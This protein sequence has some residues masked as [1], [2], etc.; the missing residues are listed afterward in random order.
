M[1][2]ALAAR[3]FA[4]PPVDAI[5]DLELESLLDLTVDVATRSPRGQRE[6]AGIVTVWDASDLRRLGCRDLADALSLIPEIQLGV[7][8]WGTTGLI[9]RGSWAFEGRVLVLVDG[10]ELN[11]TD[12]GTVVLGHRLP[13]SL[14]ERIEVLRGPGSAMYGGYASLS[15]V[16]VTTF[17]GRGDTGPRV[18]ATG[19]V[20]ASGVP[21]R[22]DVAVS[23][24]KTLEHGH[25]AASAVVG[26]GRR[27][28][29]TYTD[30]AGG[31][32]DLTHASQADPA[33][34]SADAEVGVWTMA[35]A[36][37][38]FHTTQQ[39]ANVRAW[40]RPHDADFDGIFGRLEANVRP[41]DG[42]TVRPYLRVKWQQP[43]HSTDWSSMSAYS[44]TE[45]RV[46]RT[47]LGVEAATEDDGGWTLQGGAEGGIDHATVPEVQT[48]WWFDGG[49]S[50]VYGFGSGWAQATRTLPA[51]TL[52]AGG[53]V[54]GHLA[55]GTAFSPRLA[56]THAWR[57]G[58]YKVLASRAFR[59]PGIVQARDDVDPE[60]ATV[61]EAEVGAGP[62]PWSYLTATVF[63]VRIDRPLLYVYTANDEGYANG[64]VAGNRGG[65]LQGDLLWRDWRA[66]LGWSATTAS[67]R[68]ETE[69]FAVS[70]N[71]DALLGVA[72]HKVVGTLSTL[73][74]SRL[75]LATTGSWFSPRWTVL[76]AEGGSATEEQLP[77]A[78]VWDATATL[79]LPRGLWTSLSVHDLLDQAPPF[80]QPYDGLHAPLPSSGR[81]IAVTVGW[82]P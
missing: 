57:R 45:D 37:E 74:W 62:T 55:Y 2:L 6:T 50:I 42:W 56:L 22:A 73:A 72:S 21:G 25:V 34:L 82:I 38:H 33:F 16:R 30:V 76:H 78:S 24:G 81:E 36:A 44:A 47:V 15:V 10:H 60:T 11:E 5:E 43:Y 8:V 65:G 68:N 52:T 46:D 27:S 17:A 1:L 53:R 4:S 66:S 39:D 41:A 14:I 54:D 61:L 32:V 19:S 3:A 35:L 70:G 67:G 75:S 7:D 71:A 79:S 69:A 77:A 23:G 13:A 40:K 20:L 12:Y 31:S 64:T 80:T 63:D 28:D 9:V 48:G 58:H 51:L 59:A 18:Q 49:Q 26:Q 29:R